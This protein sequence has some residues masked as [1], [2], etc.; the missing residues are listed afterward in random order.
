MKVL[1]SSYQEKTNN[2]DTNYAKNGIIAKSYINHNAPKDS[3]SFG[4]LNGGF[5]E[6]SKKVVSKVFD[7]ILANFFTTFLVV[8]S[9]SMIIPRIWVDLHRDKDKTGHFNYQAGAE[10]AG[11]EAMS[12]PSM[13]L[14]PMFILWAMNKKAPASH[15]ERETLRGMTDSMQKAV[16]NLSSLEDIKDQKKLDETLAAQIF[17]ST[18][19]EDKFALT[20]RQALKSE[21]AKLLVDS[22]TVKPKLIFGK[23]EDY[24][25]KLNAF[26]EFVSKIYNQNKN[27][28]PADSQA[29]MFDLISEDKAGKVSVSASHLFDDFHNYSK[30]VTQK[31]A[32]KTFAKTTLEACK[33]EAVN[34]LE[35]MRKNRANIKIATTMTAFFAVGSFLLYLP[36]LYLKGKVSPAMNSVKRVQSETEPVKGGCDESK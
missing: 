30:D 35:S 11:R 8:D 18:F 27:V 6:G 36:K 1:P 3:V 16:Q 21:F 33:K 4:G 24:K 17:E 34:A 29:I 32:R 9:V 5:A 14:I 31:L 25:N 19:P 2:Y 20:D 13:N 15:M 7:T 23:S 10:T 22:K 26:T 12:G 28:A